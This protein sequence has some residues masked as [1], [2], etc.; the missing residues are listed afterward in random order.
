[1]G[2][3][4]KKTWKD[5][6]YKISVVV[7]I[8][9]GIYWWFFGWIP[10]QLRGVADW[11]DPSI[12]SVV[13]KEVGENTVGILVGIF[14]LII[15]IR[16]W[17]TATDRL[18]KLYILLTGIFWFIGFMTYISGILLHKLTGPLSLTGL[19]AFPLFIFFLVKAFVAYRKVKNK[20]SYEQLQST[21]NPNSTEM[22]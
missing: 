8:V 20:L 1:M 6:V 16:L 3:Q 22:R 5:S 2:D 15:F 17:F 19:M 18:Y 12:Q 21:T 7:G 13:E 14:M 4:M 9:G 10:N 11:I